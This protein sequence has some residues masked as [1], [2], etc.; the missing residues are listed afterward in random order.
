MDARKLEVI[1][2]VGPIVLAELLGSMKPTYSLIPEIK[3]PS[4]IMEIIEDAGDKLSSFIPMETVEI[5]R[6]ELIEY[7]MPYISENLIAYDMALTKEKE[8]VS[9]LRTRLSKKEELIKELQREI[10][11][12]SY[13]V[14]M[15]E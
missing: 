11:D 4:R 5:N 13:L 9:S 3:P 14:E 12:L 6:I 7:G 8:V 10:A 1:R 15:G 2:H